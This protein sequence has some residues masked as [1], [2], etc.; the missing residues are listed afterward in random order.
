MREKEKCL[1]IADRAKRN[2]LNNLL[3][4]YIYVQRRGCYNIMMIYR[5]YLNFAAVPAAGG[6]IWT[7][8]DR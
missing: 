3:E 4:F 7:Y 2:V 1:E 6:T 5:M 8:S